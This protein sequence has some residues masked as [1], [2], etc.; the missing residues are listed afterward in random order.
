M[1]NNHYPIKNSSITWTEGVYLGS[2]GEKKT[3]NRLTVNQ[4]KSCVFSCHHQVTA[5]KYSVS[6]LTL[7]CS[8]GLLKSFE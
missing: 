1:F 7:N 5:D 8:L 3:I 6:G 4:Y 2:Q